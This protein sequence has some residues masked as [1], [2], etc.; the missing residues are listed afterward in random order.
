[1]LRSCAKIRNGHN[2]WTHQAYVS[3]SSSTHERWRR[4]LILQRV[5]ERR[6]RVQERGRLY[7]L[8]RGSGISYRRPASESPTNLGRTPAPLMRARRSDWHVEKPSTSRIYVGYPGS[9][10]KQKTRPA[11]R[12]ENKLSCSH[13]ILGSGESVPS[14]THTEVHVDNKR[15]GH[16][17]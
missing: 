13:W 15:L 2:L 3:R 1:M 17:C 6:V 10:D 12:I 4:Y 16:G 9:R 8:Y 11:P 5:G 14:M 7:G